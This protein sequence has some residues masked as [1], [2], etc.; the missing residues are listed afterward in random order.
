M[1]K[2]DL[3]EYPANHPVGSVV[4]DGGSSCAKCEYLKKGNNCGEEH[5]IGWN[6][7]T[8]I[9]APADHYCCDFFEVKAVEN[10]KFEDVGL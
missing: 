5:F 1:A 2:G 10:V 3:P 8:K 7:G 4:P 9:P 6:G